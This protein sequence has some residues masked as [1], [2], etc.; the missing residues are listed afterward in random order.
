MIE[1]A[2]LATGE[3][4]S[5]EVAD[6]VRHLT[7]VVVN[8]AFRLAPDADALAAQDKAWWSENKDAL[9][10][11]G[12]KFSMNPP[13]KSSVELVKPIAILT[14]SSNSGI[15]GVHVAITVYKATRVLLYGMDCRGKHY[16]GLH[17]RLS[18]TTPQR[19][20]VFLR[21]WADYARTVPQGVEIINRTPGSA[22]TCFPS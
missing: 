9:Q 6:S 8:D 13:P 12:R 21:Q 19:F 2:V 11:A 22:I 16:F 17:K 5:Q 14:T 1:V 7:R 3:S 18:N 4:M 20:K 10:F 15:L